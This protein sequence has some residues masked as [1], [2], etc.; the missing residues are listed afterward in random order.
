M[1]RA[2]W[3]PQ[4]RAASWA[5]GCQEGAGSDPPNIIRYISHWPEVT[6]HPVPVLSR[7]GRSLAGREGA[8]GVVLGE[9]DVESMSGWG[10]ENSDRAS[11]AWQ[12][13]R[14]GPGPHCC[15]CRLPHTHPESSGEGLTPPPRGLP[16]A[17]AVPDQ[18]ARGLFT[19]A[20]AAHP[21]LLAAVAPG[22]LGPREARR[23]CTWFRGSQEN[24]TLPLPQV[25]EKLWLLSP[26]IEAEHV[27]MSPNSFIKLQTN[28]YVTQRGSRPTARLSKSAG[29]VRAE[30]QPQCP[31]VPLLLPATETTPA[32]LQYLPMGPSPPPTAQN[33]SRFLH[34]SASSKGGK[35]QLGGVQSLE[36]PVSLR[37]ATQCGLGVGT[38]AGGQGT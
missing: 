33:F 25:F 24:G 34:K 30:G 8:W 3:S 35:C 2:V 20:L 31:A 17:P 36:C 4:G 19:S 22:S 21:Q 12:R 23:P 9:A 26:E 38:S 27:L 1:Q 32:R 28:R 16:S 18:H 10:K 37:L 14:A 6:R 13:R 11:P 7:F 15:M 29:A 5:W